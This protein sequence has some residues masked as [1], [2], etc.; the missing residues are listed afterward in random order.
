MPAALVSEHR[1]FNCERASPLVGALGGAGLGL[2]VP[3]LAA[4]SLFC[5]C[6]PWDLERAFCKHK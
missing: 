3:F 5:M 4:H 6:V 2:A 1:T